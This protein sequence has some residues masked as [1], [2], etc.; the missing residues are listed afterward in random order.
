MLNRCLYK[1]VKISYIS[2]MFFKLLNSISISFSTFNMQMLSISRLSFIIKR[3]C[4]YA[5][6]ISPPCVKLSSCLLAACFE[7]HQP[8]SIGWLHS[9]QGAV[10]SLP[11][12]S[13][14]S[15]QSKIAYCSFCLPGLF[16]FYC[17]LYVLVNSLEKNRSAVIWL[18]C[19]K[20]HLYMIR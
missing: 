9:S 13:S 10:C 15:T 12:C 3:S 16:C 7:W 4:L 14:S 18:S 11:D 5:K 20:W 19:F 8:S 17:V 1:W 2:L 6:P